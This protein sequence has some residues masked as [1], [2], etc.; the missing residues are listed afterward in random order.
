MFLDIK[1]KIVGAAL[2][3]SAFTLAGAF[4]GSLTPAI[5]GAL[6]GVAASAF[7]AA[8]SCRKLE[9]LYRLL[10]KNGTG[11]M[12]ST[13]LFPQMAEQGPL[14][15]ITAETLTYNMERRGFYRASLEASGSMMLMCDT[16]CVITHASASY[17]RLLKKDR[18]K[19]VGKTVAEAM[20][21]GTRA[22]V[23][24]KVIEE[25]CDF[26][27]E[28]MVTL[29]D[30]RSV[31][32]KRT[33]NPIMD[34]QGKVAGAVATLMDLS[35]LWTEREN[36][37]RRDAAMSAAAGE[38]NNVAGQLSEAAK[39][40]ASTAEFQAHCATS[41]NDSVL[42]FSSAINQLT[43]TI[44]HIARN[45]E[46]TT[47]KTRF[48]AS[49]AEDSAN[50]VKDAVAGINTV[51]ASTARLSEDLHALDDQ[52]GGIGRVVSVITDIA[53][54]TN[55]LALN[56]AIEAARAGE[57]GR[58]FAVVADAV[59]KLAEKTMQATKEV[60]EAIGDIQKQSRHTISGMEE[61]ERQVEQSTALTNQVGEALEAIVGHL[62][63]AEHGVA[64]VA[65]AVQDQSE[66]A[67]HIQHNVESISA[68]STQVKE[69]SQEM[70]RMARTLT[71][72]SGALLNIAASFRGI[73]GE[74]K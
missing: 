38:V 65:A 51:A 52:A 28:G 19:V 58:G 57:A 43:S 29:W 54:Q 55:L 27:D 15:K 42:Q 44:A 45:T 47:E 33:I 7:L 56:A 23:V 36:L 74:K 10:Q 6:A 66:A 1:G 31:P 40:T 39:T 64:A 14:G 62:R 46:D 2:C 30:G 61:T 11:R 12:D 16:D 20:Y 67:I 48:T 21:G 34:S 24:S 18:S 41:L 49:L 50:I 26:S 32:L 22:A 73:C 3:G 59:R 9:T 63:D 60:T 25:R 13:E 35:D 72:V 53:D 71:D 8:H 37:C 68:E 5:W 70:E 17:L 69:S 4:T